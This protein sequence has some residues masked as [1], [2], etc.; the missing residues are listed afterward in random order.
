MELESDIICMRN[1]V[2]EMKYKTKEVIDRGKEKLNKRKGHLNRNFYQGFAVLLTGTTHDKHQRHSSCCHDAGN[3]GL[4]VSSS[5]TNYLCSVT[6][7][8]NANAMQSNKKAIEG[9]G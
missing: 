7:K 1:E 9:L 6:K 8:L 2:R 5:S 3:C 4:C